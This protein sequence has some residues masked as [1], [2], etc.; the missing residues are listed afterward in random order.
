MHANCKAELI[1]IWNGTDTQKQ[2]HI[3]A[4]NDKVA[5]VRDGQIYIPQQFHIWYFPSNATLTIIIIIYNYILELAAWGAALPQGEYCVRQGARN[6]VGGPEHC[7]S[8]KDASPSSAAALHLEC[9]GWR[10]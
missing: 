5:E 6:T 7:D 10:Y 2:K 8:R 9:L 4:I 3:V 1:Y